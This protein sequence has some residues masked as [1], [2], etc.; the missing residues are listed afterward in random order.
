MHHQQPVQRP[1]E[2]Q[3]CTRKTYDFNSAGKSIYLSI[4]LSIDLSFFLSIYIRHI[5]HIIFAMFARIVV[6]FF[7]S[8]SCNMHS[9]FKYPDVE[10]QPSITWVFGLETEMTNEKS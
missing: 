5:Y 3:L 4:Y 1:A 10:S 6:V 9:R 2:G 7:F 8:L